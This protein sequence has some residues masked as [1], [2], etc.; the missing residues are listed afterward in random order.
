MSILNSPLARLALCLMIDADS[1]LV[2]FVEAVDS[3]VNLYLVVPAEAMKLTYVCELLESAVRLRTI[4]TQFA[5]EA[6]LG[7]NLLGHL[8]YGDFLACTYVDVAVAYFLYAV[9]VVDERLIV[10]DILK[11]H[12]QKAVNRSVCHLLAPENSRIGAPEPQS[13]TA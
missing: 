11:V 12:I 13:V 9:A 1:L 5:L 2:P 8:T 10:E 4:P 3:L 7:H 6:N